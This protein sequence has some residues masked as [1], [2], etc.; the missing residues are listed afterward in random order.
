[1]GKKYKFTGETFKLNDGTV[2]DRIKGMKC[3]FIHRSLIEVEENEKPPILCDV[4]LQNV[5]MTSEDCGREDVPFEKGKIYGF[6]LE[7]NG[8]TKE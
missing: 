4:E 7:F 1:M 8:K 6:S 2:L 3:A 5:S